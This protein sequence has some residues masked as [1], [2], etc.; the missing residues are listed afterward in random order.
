MPQFPTEIEI[1][2]RL[3]AALQPESNPALQG[4]INSINSSLA[5]ELKC[6][7]VLLPLFRKGQEWHLIFTRRT[8]AVE[9][10]KG[11]VSFPGGGCD[12]HETTPAQTALREAQEEIGL[13]PQDVHILGKLKDVVTIS[14]FR[15]T[16]VIGV[17]PWPYTFHL[18]LNEVSRVFSMPLTW[19]AQPENWDE[20]NFTPEGSPR[21]F[22]VITYH[23]YDGEVLWGASARITHNFLEVLNLIQHEDQIDHGS[24]V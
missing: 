7:A 21:S 24:L 12:E 8:D 9:D 6:A 19:L 16:P 13:L 17:I 2:K 1:A 11:Q 15:V 5:T 22:P 10:H 14:H 20:F 18:S 23:T 4:Y 3:Q